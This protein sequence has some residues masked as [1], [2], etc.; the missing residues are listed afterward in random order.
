MTSVEEPFSNV[1]EAV[2]GVACPTMVE[3]AYQRD[4]ATL[5]QFHNSS[6]HY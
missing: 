1:S 5:H 4:D 3:I 2:E 6:E